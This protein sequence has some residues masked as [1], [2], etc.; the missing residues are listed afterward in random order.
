MMQSI[1]SRLKKKKAALISAALA[2]ALLASGL[3]TASAQQ[4]AAACVITKTDTNPFF[5]NIRNAAIVEG[6]K[7]NI[8]VTAH[9]GRED[10]DTA[11]QVD[12]VE[13]CILAGAK[14]ILITPSD[15]RAIVPV[16]Q[17]ARDA[18]LLVL[19]IDTPVSPYDAV[20][21][22][23]ATDNFNAGILIGQWA[24]AKLGDEAD[25]ARIAFLDVHNSQVTVDVNRSQGFMH[26]FGIDI[27][28]PAV[29]GDEKDPR[30]VGHDI[31]QGNE[32]GGRRAMENLLQ[33]DP[34]LNVVYTV[35]EPAAAGAYEALKAVGREK[36]V[37]MVSVDGGCQGVRNI[38][39]GSLMATA[40]QY[41]SQMAKMGIQALRHWLDT[42]EKPATQ[43]GK[44][45]IDTGVKLVTDQPLEGLDS[46]SSKEGLDICWGN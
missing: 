12:A 40:Q 8:K 26:G 25:K 46:I 41:P 32:E 45:F 33:V 13:A 36:E 27:G 42:G 17:Q 31:T 1:Q 35:N 23:Y 3:S 24:K 20:D 5:V 7:L 29:I 44:E 9:A 10:G 43:A 37:I 16:L 14:G 15:D 18:G 28:N 19:A 38:A 39:D 34:L 6:Q 30:I 11:G 2:V 21:G 22:T 4:S